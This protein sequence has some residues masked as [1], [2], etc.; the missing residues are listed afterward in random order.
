MG[1]RLSG[2]WRSSLVGDLLLLVGGVLV[3]AFLLEG[4]VRLFMGEQPKFPR[5]VVGAPF[6]LLINEP[7][8]R[9]RHK[10]ADLSIEIR[11]NGQG[12]RADREYP[13]QKDPS[14]KRIVA[15]GDSFTMGLEVEREQ[16]FSSVLERELRAR[17]HAVEVLN[18]GVSGYSTGEALLYLEREL[19]D[20][21]PDVVLISFYGND[22]ADNVETG[23]FRLEE[24]RLV[25]G[26]TEYLPLGGIADLLNRNPLL[27]LLSE[28]SDAFV[29]LKQLGTTILKRRAL[30][31]RF[32]RVDPGDE[33]VV[34]DEEVAYARHLTAALYE[35]LYET[36]RQAG[37]P[38]VVQSIPS[39]RQNPAR[40]V[41]RF[42]V[43]EVELHRPGLYFLAAKDVLAPLL[44]R[45]PLYWRRSYGHWTPAAHERAG[46]ALVELMLR[47][48]LV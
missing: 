17:G 38:L 13:K 29:L 6:G 48:G 8:A 43:K 40:L 19:L 1:S 4:G 26:A 3:G 31:R 7:H 15:L 23:L 11:I 20:Y 44:G 24:G 36:T 25:P 45:T 14:L 18:T 41:E 35:R 21:H 22:L 39:W 46:R 42:P 30:E 34:E 33:G 2:W 27:G 12:M 47:E 9:Y 37:L 10:S 16:C 28:R 32:D 5:R